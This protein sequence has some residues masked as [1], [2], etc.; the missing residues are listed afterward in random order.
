MNAPQTKG[1]IADLATRIA[2]P[3]RQAQKKLRLFAGII[4]I[5]GA[6]QLLGPVI[7]YG[8]ASILGVGVFLVLLDTNEADT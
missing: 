5:V 8:I 6:N 4:A 3:N 7:G 1:P 2:G